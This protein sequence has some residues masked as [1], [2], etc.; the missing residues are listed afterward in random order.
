MPNA[1]RT[2]PNIPGGIEG[3]MHLNHDNLADAVI[4]YRLVQF[5]ARHHKLQI[6]DLTRNACN[7]HLPEAIT[8]HEKEFPKKYLEH[9]CDDKGCIARLML[10]DGNAKVC[11]PVCAFPGCSLL[12]ILGNG[13][14]KSSRFCDTHI[15]F[16]A[17]VSEF[18]L[19]FP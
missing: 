3:S 2:V 9:I 15:G 13:K 17:L 12:P 4:I 6:W 10:M 7:E 18:F 16:A 1:K 14:K 5:G 11:M 8:I 19:P